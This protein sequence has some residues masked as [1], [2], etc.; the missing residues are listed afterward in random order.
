MKTLASSYDLKLFMCSNNKQQRDTAVLWWSRQEH[1]FVQHQKV[2]AGDC[3]SLAVSFRRRCIHPVTAAASSLQTNFE[4]EEIETINSGADH[5]KTIHVR[6][7]LHKECEFGQQFLIVGDD[8]IIGLWDPSEGVPLNWSDGHLW[9][10]EM[11]IPSGKM[12]KYKFILKGDT[13]IISW[14]TGPDRILETWDTD[15]TIIVFEDWDNPELQHIFEE[16]DL[17]DET[18][19]YSE[20]LILD[21]ELN[22]HGERTFEPM[23]A[24]NITE[25]SRE[26]DLSFVSGAVITGITDQ[27]KEEVVYGNGSNL[28]SSK[29]EGVHVLVPGLIQM[30]EEEMEETKLKPVVENNS[31]ESTTAEFDEIETKNSYSSDI[32]ACPSELTTTIITQKEDEE[33]KEEAEQ[34]EDETSEL[35]IKDDEKGRFCER[36][37]M[38]EDNVL[39]SA[40]QWGRQTL[41]KFLANF[42]FSMTL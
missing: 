23:V 24:E 19:I 17:N 8:P 34:E 35:M 3:C 1:A 12:M 15:K 31:V 11:D 38:E 18:L 6:F 30:A 4:S 25:E 40:M 22:N 33:E 37:H 29:D 41:Q 21:E 39:E 28:L 26:Q 2:G 9:T 14:Q 32:A 16:D 5:P 7:K 36:E 13:G 27:T 42:G 20:L 10:A